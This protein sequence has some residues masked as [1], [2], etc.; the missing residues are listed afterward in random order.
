MVGTSVRDRMNERDH[1]EDHGFGHRREQIARDAVQ[2]EHRHE[3]DADA[4]QGHESRGDDLLRAVEDGGASH[5][6]R[7]RDAS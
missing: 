1:G 2:R 5:P 6:C 4:E 3:H 7:V